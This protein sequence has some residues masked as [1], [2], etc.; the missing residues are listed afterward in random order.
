VLLLLLQN[1]MV[2]FA[3]VAAERNISSSKRVHF[4]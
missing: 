4:N 2:G 1:S 3:I